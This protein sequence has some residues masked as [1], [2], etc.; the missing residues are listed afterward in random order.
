MLVS[1][2]EARRIGL[3]KYFTGVPC[4]RG[5]IAYRYVKGAECIECQK[6][7]SKKW[8][9]DTDRARKKTAGW[10][11][12]NPERNLTNQRRYVERNRERVR[13]CETVW[14]EKN[15]SKK[16]GYCKKW[17]GKNRKGEQERARIKRA[18]NIEKYRKYSVQWNAD[19]PGKVAAIAR[20]RRARA[21]KGGKHSY[22]DVMA[23]LKKQKGGCV[24]CKTA[25]G[26]RYHVDHIM[27]LARGGSNDRT[28]L[29]ILCAPCNQSKSARDPIEFMQQR[30]MLL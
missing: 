1:R 22:D 26:N 27:P 23:L 3:S 25:F 16:R 7:K 11:A 2:V 10:R 4:H 8:Y 30:G 5:H 18:K 29:Q 9:S 17:Y 15:R 14:A 24:I 21:A 28:N 6:E 20:N 13:Q 19:N 12:K